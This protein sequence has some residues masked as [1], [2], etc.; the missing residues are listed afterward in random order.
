MPVPGAPWK[1]ERVD[2]DDGSISYEVYS[3]ASYGWLF[4][5]NERDNKDA[6]DTTQKIV[7]CVNEIAVLENLAHDGRVSAEGIGIRVR[8]SAAATS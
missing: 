3:L 4:A 5:I 8:Q 1:V 2:W 7:N 6:K